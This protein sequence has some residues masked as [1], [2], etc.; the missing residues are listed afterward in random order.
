MMTGVLDAETA[1]VVLSSIDG[2]GACQHKCAKEYTMNIGEFE[3][4]LIR[5]YDPEL[6]DHFEQVGVTIVPLEIEDLDLVGELIDEINK[7]LDHDHSKN[8][9]FLYKHSI[10]LRL[11]GPILAITKSF[12][13]NRIEVCSA[14]FGNDLVWYED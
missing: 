8:D 3:A 9:E 1:K 13:K 2:N 5:R 12:Y 4:D 7:Q 10:A 11:S 6:A 14:V